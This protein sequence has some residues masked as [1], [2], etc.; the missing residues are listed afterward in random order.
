[1]ENL[2]AASASPSLL[3]QVIARAAAMTDEAE[4]VKQAQLREE[5]QIQ[6]PFDGAIAKIRADSNDRAVAIDKEKE[7]HLLR[8]KNEYK[9]RKQQIQAARDS[10]IAA[11]EQTQQM[12]ERDAA[13]KAAYARNQLQA[14]ANAAAQF[15]AQRFQVVPNALV[16]VGATSAARGLSGHAQAVP[17][18]STS[19]AQYAAATDTQAVNMALA[20]AAQ[21]SSNYNTAAAQITATTGQRATDSASQALQLKRMTATHNGDGNMVTTDPAHISSDTSSST[22]SNSTAL[23]LTAAADALVGHV[24][25]SRQHTAQSHAAAATSHQAAAHQAA[26]AAAPQQAAHQHTSNAGAANICSALAVVTRAILALMNTHTLVLRDEQMLQQCLDNLPYDAATAFAVIVAIYGPEYKSDFKWFTRF[27]AMYTHHSKDRSGNKPNL[28]EHCHALQNTGFVYV[29]NVDMIIDVAALNTSQN[30]TDKLV[31]EK[32]TQWQSDEVFQRK[33]VLH[34]ITQNIQQQ[35]TNFEVCIDQAFMQQLHS[36]QQRSGTAPHHMYEFKSIIGDIWYCAKENILDFC[37]QTNVNNSSRL[38]VTQVVSQGNSVL[39]VYDLHALAASGNVVDRL[40]YLAF[41][42]YAQPATVHDVQQLLAAVWPNEI[43]AL[44]QQVHAIVMANFKAVTKVR[45]RQEARMKLYS[46]QGAIKQA[47]L[48]ELANS[49]NS[50]LTAEVVSTAA[51][52][53]TSSSHTALVCRML[54]LVIKVGKQLKP[55]PSYAALL[56][57]VSTNNS[58]SSSSC[59]T[60]SGSSTTRAAA[61]AAAASNSVISST[62]RNTATAGSK[63]K[64]ASSVS[65]SE[66]ANAHAETYDLSITTDTSSDDANKATTAKT[67]RV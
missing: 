67:A 52:D 34:V 25:A 8:L 40:R 33:A 57:P 53:T 59:N 17:A 43:V 60:G 13:A 15:L 32:Y 66:H 50:K 30:A 48:R 26:A 18:I 11:A 38:L 45:K 10:K 3:E 12:L 54:P 16:P 35:S 6:Q 4:K 22:G 19:T 27:D 29:E 42:G 49:F 56:C 23:T 44:M 20:A 65:A 46:V 62:G 24:Q 31:A 64:A 36:V 58:S 51:F 5:Q 9:A 63:R 28:P 1:M 7:D 39:Y 41:R 37:R 14:R 21:N 61:A 47:D 2:K 55:N